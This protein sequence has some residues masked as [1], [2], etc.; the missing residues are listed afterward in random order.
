MN[1]HLLIF[2]SV[3]IKD[4]CNLCESGDPYDFTCV[5]PDNT[6]TN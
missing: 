6:I 3:M 1:F 2:I 4:V 5:I